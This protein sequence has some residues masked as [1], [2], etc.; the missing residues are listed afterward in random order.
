MRRPRARYVRD[1]GG[2]VITATVLVDELRALGRMRL[3]VSGVEVLVVW[4]DGEPYAIENACPH[5]GLPLSAGVVKGCVI[6]CPAHLRQFDVRSGA[7][8]DDPRGEVLRTYPSRIV[9]G[10][11]GGIV[12]VDVLE[13]LQ[14]LS[15][16]QMLLANARGASPD[17]SD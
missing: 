13:T 1:C 9:A 15:M 6:T 11:G 7:R 10:P 16:R 2:D 8:H 4:A 17:A 3:A 5:R 14:S 12:V